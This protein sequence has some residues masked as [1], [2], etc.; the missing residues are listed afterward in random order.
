M[1]SRQTR[2]ASAGAEN[3]FSVECIKLIVDGYTVNMIRLHQARQ[4]RDIVRK[5]RGVASAVPSVVI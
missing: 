3:K 5:A 4:A 1:K 2:L